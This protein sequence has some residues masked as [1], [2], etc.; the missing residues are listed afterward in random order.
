[1]YVHDSCPAPPGR[2]SVAMSGQTM[3]PKSL[4]PGNDHPAQQPHTGSWPRPCQ[5]GPLGAGKAR[6]IRAR[7]P[8]PA[9]GGTSA[10]NQ[11][12]ASRRHRDSCPMTAGRPQL[13]HDGGGCY[14]QHRRLEPLKDHNC[15]MAPVAHHAAF[16][17]QPDRARRYMPCSRSSASWQ[18]SSLPAAAWS[19]ETSS[20]PVQLIGP[21]TPAIKWIL[22]VRRVPD[23]KPPYACG[24]SR[25]AISGAPMSPGHGAV[26]P[27]A[28]L[29]TVGAE[30]RKRTVPAGNSQ[31]GVQSGAPSCYNYSPRSLSDY[32]LD[33][34]A[35]RIRAVLIQL[36]GGEWVRMRGSC[37]RPQ[38]RQGRP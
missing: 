31:A 20:I 30:L 6:G 26:H 15:G 12:N 34:Y 32:E 3:P 27:R 28:A 24:G 1:M 25:D 7:T 5:S 35:K 4:P 11:H 33:H 22:N 36:A 19:G 13:E 17:W 37:H 9:P 14:G 2:C 29:R 23:E 21:P 18:E 8:S 16:R 38:G 10:R